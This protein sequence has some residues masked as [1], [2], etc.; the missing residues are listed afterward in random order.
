MKVRSYMNRFQY[1]ITRYASE[2]FTSL[3]Y[4]CTGDGSCSL[5]EV[6][7]DQVEI[8]KGILNDRGEKGWEL[9][10]LIF[11][12]EGIIAFWKREIGPDPSTP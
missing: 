1:E 8:L 10:Q 11:S 2:E 12:K 3:V 5:N 6:P 4:S 9:L 7:I